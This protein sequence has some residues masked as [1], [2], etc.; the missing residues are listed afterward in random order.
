[1]DH[2]EVIILSAL[3]LA[4]ESLGHLIHI[5]GSLLVTRKCVSALKGPIGKFKEMSI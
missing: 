3:F 1:M 5:L 2:Q 4:A